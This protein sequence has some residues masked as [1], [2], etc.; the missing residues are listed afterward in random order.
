MQTPAAWLYLIAVFPPLVFTYLTHVIDDPYLRHAT[1]LI[2]SMLLVP[3]A[4][5][6]TGPVG[7]VQGLRKSKEP[8][9]EKARK[10]LNKF[11]SFEDLPAF[12][13]SM[14]L[15]LSSVLI[16]I[17]HSVLAVGASFGAFGSVE[18]L[19]TKPRWQQKL[20]LALVRAAPETALQFV[21]SV[22][23][24]GYFI[25]AGVGPAHEML[26]K[27]DK[28]A[29][30]G[31]S[32]AWFYLSI[33][34]NSAY[35]VEHHNH[36]TYLG[37]DMDS[38]SAPKGS[39]VYSYIVRMEWISW[40]RSF[41]TSFDALR[42]SSNIVS[43]MLQDRFASGL[44][45]NAVM[46]GVI[47]MA[48]GKQAAMYFVALGITGI[49]YL[50]TVNYMQHYGLRRKVDETTGKL[51]RVG[52]QHSWDC[53]HLVSNLLTFNAGA[54]ADHHIDGVVAYPSLDNG[55]GPE[56]PYG[57]HV[58]TW[59]ALVPPLFWSVADPLV[60]EVCAKY[61]GSDKSPAAVKAH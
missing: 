29:S 34:M 23:S 36:H 35:F 59:M 17:L 7:H 8:S 26:H 51:E 33:C 49:L 15:A 56:F 40:T 46:I 31:R 13:V 57:L 48:F 58:M 22:L 28:T 45:L 20:V 3:I 2:F 1:G 41:K 11:R 24:I 18:T 61:A 19:A 32:L 5:T 60:D 38:A 27:V 55:I 54:H 10:T 21:L 44:L 16:C 12:K 25:L 37:T 6:I 9:R 47:S 42:R 4:E 52:R 50:D 39:N 43:F 30:S 14:M 53:S